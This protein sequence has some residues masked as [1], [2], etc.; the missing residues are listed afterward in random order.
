MSAERR[1]AAN[2]LLAELAAASAYRCEWCHAAARYPH[3]DW[4]GACPL[5]A[6]ASSAYL[7][8]NNR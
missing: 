2:D 1:E 4:C 5:P 7:W 6:E 8:R 3:P